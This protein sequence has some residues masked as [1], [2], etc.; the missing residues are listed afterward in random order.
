MQVAGCVG[1]LLESCEGDGL[2]SG[3][4]QVVLVAGH[5]PNGSERVRVSPVCWRSVKLKRRV[6]STLAGEALAL[7]QGMAQVEWMQVMLRRVVVGD[8]SGDWVVAL[9]ST[10]PLHDRNWQVHVVDAKF[11]F[12]VIQKKGGPS[13]KQDRRRAVKL[14]IVSEA[15]KRDLRPRSD[16]F[17]ISTCSLMPLPR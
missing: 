13:P 3:G 10:S 7:S 17:R 14:A 5:L 16:A 4:T 6:P 12:D 1:L 15:M 11:V 2:P 8:V 9:P